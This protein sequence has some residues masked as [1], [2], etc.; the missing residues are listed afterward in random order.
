MIANFDTD[1]SAPAS[2]AL[3]VVAQVV[4]SL[5]ETVAGRTRAQQRRL[6]K[7][8]WDSTS[9]TGSLTRSLRS[10]GVA[11]AGRGVTVI[12]IRANVRMIHSPCFTLPVAYSPTTL[13]NLPALLL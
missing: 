10:A 5:D 11:I 2:I 3:R 6:Q 12:G 9:S 7:G 4:E 8:A 13:S 1:G